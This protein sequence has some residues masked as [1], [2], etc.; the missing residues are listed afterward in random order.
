MELVGASLALRTCV[1][2]VV[3]MKRENGLFVKIIGGNGLSRLH[4]FIRKIK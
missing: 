3:K 4:Y 2:R 1:R